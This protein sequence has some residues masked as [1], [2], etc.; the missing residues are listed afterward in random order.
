[1]DYGLEKIGRRRRRERTD[2]QFD[3]D[4]HW[5][6]MN[7]EGEVSGG[8]VELHIGL[9]H[10]MIEWKSEGA[11]RTFRSFIHTLNR[12]VFTSSS[13][14]RVHLKLQF[15]S[16]CILYEEV[17]P[18]LEERIH[19]LHLQWKHSRLSRLLWTKRVKDTFTAV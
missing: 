3:S 13:G 19:C 1:M 2:P 17:K 9:L 4:N 5:R 11:K 14:D 15:L 12:R 6:L 10:K 8:L 7:S 18:L 16:S